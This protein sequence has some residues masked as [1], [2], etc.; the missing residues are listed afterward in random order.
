MLPA[1]QVTGAVNRGSEPGNLLPDLD[2]NSVVGMP[3]SSHIFLPAHVLKR[4]S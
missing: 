4:G 3:V 2:N 1:E